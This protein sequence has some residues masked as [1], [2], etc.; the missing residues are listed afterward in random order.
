MITFIIVLLIMG[1]IIGALARL[2]VPGKDPMSIPVT[3]AIGVL[4]TLISGFIGRAI[5][6]ADGR[7]GSWILALVVTI[8]L[9]LLVRQM[10]VN[11]SSRG[12]RLRS[13]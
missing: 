10:R 2:L 12:R 4:G 6:G 9:V 5:F 3:M 8:V 11:G 13:H 7:F 1:L